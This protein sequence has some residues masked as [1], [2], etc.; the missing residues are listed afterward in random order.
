MNLVP[1][2]S[3]FDVDDL[4]DFWA[5]MRARDNAAGTFAPRVDIK[6]VDDHYEITAELPGVDK[7]DVDVSL[8]NGILTINA[9]TRD[10]DVEKKDGRIIRQERRY[11]RYSRSFDVGAGINEADIAAT[12]KD[13][14]LT[15]RAPKSA[16]Q[17]AEAKRIKV[18]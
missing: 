10:E 7:D 16:P 11:G 15:L 12:F 9:E 1:R 3:L 4:F 8:H 13:G 17:K 6:E 2:R 18:G 5:P 14:V